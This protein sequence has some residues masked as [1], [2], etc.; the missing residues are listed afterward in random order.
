MVRSSSEFQPLQFSME[1]IRATIPPQFFIRDTARS[2][3][4]LARDFCLAIFTGLT[5]FYLNDALRQVEVSA[6]P[7]YSVLVLGARTTIWCLYWWYQGLILTG[8]WVIGHECGH[9]AF[10]SSRTLCDIIGFVLHTALWTP[11]FS[12]R[13]THHRH[14]A[15]HASMEK[16]EVYVPKTRSD[17]GIPPLQDGSIDWE[18]YFGDTPLWTLLMLVRQQLFAFPAYLF[19]NVS[20]QKSYPPW[21]NHF[22]SRSVLFTRQQRNAVLLSNMGILAAAVLTWKAMKTFGAAVVLQYYG[23][24]WLLVTH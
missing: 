9:G 10:S 21:T 11:Y 2:L 22:N 18:D 14:H 15:N 3:L 12:W 4:Y 16:D 7:A 1:E 19:F 24:P 17:L 20:G 23:V 5:I 13:I 6:S 8:I